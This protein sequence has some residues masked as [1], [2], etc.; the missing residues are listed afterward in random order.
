[1][2]QRPFKCLF[3]NFYG[4]LYVIYLPLTLSPP[5]MTH[6]VRTRFIRAGVR[7]IVF[8]EIEI[9]EKLYSP[10]KMTLKI[11][12]GGGRSMHSLTFSPDPPLVIAYNSKTQCKLTFVSSELSFVAHEIFLLNETKL[13]K[14]EFP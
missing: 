14:H 6:F 7:I 4:K 2:L 5:N 9:I 11:G 13:T 12:G 3:N 1:M 10:A 8:K